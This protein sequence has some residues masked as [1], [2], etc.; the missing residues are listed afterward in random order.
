MFLDNSSYLDNMHLQIQS[1]NM[2]L[3]E[4]VFLI[5]N[6][7]AL[8]PLKVLPIWSI[9]SSCSLNLLQFGSI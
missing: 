1:Q 5:L 6:F 8:H 2:M 9:Y 4:P 7:K 3:S